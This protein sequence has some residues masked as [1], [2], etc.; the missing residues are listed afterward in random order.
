MGKGCPLDLW[1]K[2]KSQDLDLSKSVLQTVQVFHEQRGGG[3]VPVQSGGVFSLFFAFCFVRVA[4]VTFP[5]RLVRKFPP[6][7]LTYQ[8][9]AQQPRGFYKLD[10]FDEGT[11]SP[12]SVCSVCCVRLFVVGCCSFEFRVPPRFWSVIGEE[13]RLHHLCCHSC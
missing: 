5:P 8:T 4:R 6:R 13:G 1:G 11:V 10:V 7:A 9:T 12:S 3:V 2:P